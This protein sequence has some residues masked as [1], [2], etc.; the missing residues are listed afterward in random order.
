[1]HAIDGLRYA[2]TFIAMRDK[3]FKGIRRL[4]LDKRASFRPDSGAKIQNLG[5]GYMLID[6]EALRSRKI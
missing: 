2:I 5:N 6:P 3:A 4:I 1:M